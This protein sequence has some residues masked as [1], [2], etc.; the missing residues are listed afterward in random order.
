MK[1]TTACLTMWSTSRTL[2]THS[3]HRH[4]LRSATATLGWCADIWQQGPTN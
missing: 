2:T 3:V 4:S 1:T